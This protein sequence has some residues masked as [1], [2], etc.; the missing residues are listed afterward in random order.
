MDVKT[1]LVGTW[2]D[3]MDMARITINKPPSGKEPSSKWKHK[4][5]RSEH[6]PIRNMFVQ[7][8]WTDLPSWVS[9]HIVRHKFGIDHFVGTQRTDRTGVN[10]SELPQGSLVTHGALISFQAIINISRS[11]L[12]RMASKETR[13]AWR[14]MLDSFIDVEPELHAACVRQCVYRGKCNEFKSCGFDS[15]ELFTIEKEEYN[16]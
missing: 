15:S 14:A 16:D 13:Q 5:L 9:V 10:R 4:I 11:R 1:K 3:V 2:Q 12:C 8:I 7:A 6:S